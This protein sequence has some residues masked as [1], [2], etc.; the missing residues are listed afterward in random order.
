MAQHT[1]R[2]AGREQVTDLVNEVGQD[3]QGLGQCQ[4]FG[5]GH[6]DAD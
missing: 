2:G 6:P 3:V 1:G 5:G 4:G